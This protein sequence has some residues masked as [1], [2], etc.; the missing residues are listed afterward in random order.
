MRGVGRVL[1]D[2]DGGVEFREREG[3]GRWGEDG[4]RVENERGRR[5]GTGVRG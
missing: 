2:M 3:R 1:A 4:G 5:E